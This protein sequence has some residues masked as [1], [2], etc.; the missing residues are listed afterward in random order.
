[1]NVARFAE[2]QGRAVLLI[3]LL[4]AGAGALVVQSLP[5]DIYPPLQFP[6]LLVIAHSG[7]LPARSMMTSVTRPLEQATM[8]VPGIRRVR[9]RTFRGATEISA[10][11]DPNTDMAAALQQ[12]QNRVV[13][14]RQDLPA[15][16]SLVV[17]RLTVSSFP[18]LSLNLTGGLPT[19]DLNDYAFYVIRPALARVPGVGRVEV[20]ATD[21][22]EIEVVADPG[23]LLAAGL[24]V[25]DVTTA[26]KTANRLAPVGHYAAGGLEH[27]VLA[28]ALWGSAAE[29]SRTTVAV[30]NG[31]TIRVADVATVFPGSPDRTSLITGNGQDASVVSISQQPGASILAVKA[32]IEQTLNDLAHTL[33]S[34]LRLSKV[35]DLAE[36]VATA[37]ANVR[38]AILIGGVLAVLVLLIFLRD[39]R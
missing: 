16:T 3:T 24:T 6:R 34:G 7:S 11:F 15:E 38:D 28:S 25:D 2:R 8:E 9:S 21:T 22:R 27:L 5:S 39:W 23:R 36:F 18:M 31:A 30:R 13:E 35:Y 20:S 12:L 1:M 19:P 10:Q 29:I 26:L 4:L 37:I 33:P 32:G 14:V 17:E